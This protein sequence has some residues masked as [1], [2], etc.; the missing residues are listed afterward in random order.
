MLVRITQWYTRWVMMEGG[1]S[2]VI[3]VASLD[4]AEQ[5]ME[6]VEPPD[7]VEKFIKKEISIDYEGGNL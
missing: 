1:M 4:E 7:L 3:E 5:I 6:G 2:T